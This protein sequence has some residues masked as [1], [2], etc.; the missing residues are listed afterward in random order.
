MKKTAVVILNFN[1]RNYLEMFLPSLLAYS[2]NSE[3]VVIDNQSTD[4]SLAFLSQAYPDQVKV[5]ELPENLGFAGGYNE[6]LKQ[7]KADYYAI[8]NSDIEVTEQWLDPLVRFLDENP[9]YAACQPKIKAYKDK[10]KFEYAG[11][12]GGFLDSFGYPY[13]R[14]RI[15]DEVEKD[16]G[17]YQKTTDVFWTSGACM[18]IRSKAFWE[19]GAFDQDFFAHMEEIDLCWRLHNLN[20]KLACVPASTVYHVG[21]GTL[22]KSNPR[23]TYL[24]FRNGLSLLYKNLPKRHLWKIF[25]RM[26]LDGFAAIKFG[27]ENDFVHTKAVFI[28]HL[29]FYGQLRKN[30]Q[31]R[32]IAPRKDIPGELKHIKFLAWYFYAAGNRIFTSKDKRA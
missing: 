27:L 21:G 13:C 19:A 1:G 24:N 22:A 16:H 12:A 4:D 28:A 26:I 14:G 23:K 30:T 5:I 15:F 18:L 29:H 9:D 25:V 2:G 11:A 8:V 6:G 17:Q 20:Y 32:K 31:K 10:E 7:V 3:I